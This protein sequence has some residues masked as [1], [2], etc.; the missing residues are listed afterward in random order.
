MYRIQIM[1]HLSTADVRSGLRKADSSASHVFIMGVVEGGMAGGAAAP[2]GRIKGVAKWASKG[3][4]SIE[5][6]IFVFALKILI[7]DASVKK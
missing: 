3:I 6:V 1:H 2:G 7:A 4:F 5:N